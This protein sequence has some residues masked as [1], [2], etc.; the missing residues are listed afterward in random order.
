MA[1]PAAPVRAAAEAVGPT[2]A[3]PVVVAAAAG[4]SVVAAAAQAPTAPLVVAA[5]RA[6][7]RPARPTRPP[8][9][10]RR[11]RSRSVGLPARR[12]R[13]IAAPVNGATY[14]QG[15][16][17]SSSFTC[18]EG[19][20]GLGISSCVDQAAGQSG[21]ALDTSTPGS[22]TDP[23]TA[24]STDG[25]TGSAS[26]TYTVAGPPGA[27]ITA[28]ASGGSYTLNQDVAVTFTCTPGTDAPALSSCAG[29]DGASAGSGVL[30]T[31][32]LGAHTYTVTATSSDGQSATAQLAYTVTAP[33]Q[34]FAVSHIQ[35][36]AHGLVTLQV[37]APGAGTVGVLETTPHTAATAASAHLIIVGHK[38][39][40]VS[41]AT[42]LHV[43]L[44]LNPR[45]RAM[46]ARRGNALAVRLWVTYTP[47]SGTM[48]GRHVYRVPR[49]K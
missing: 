39:L 1:A 26:A 47:R 29:S 49:S 30:D 40:T 37:T 45:G 4:S 20:G 19:T 10:H 5:V 35:R 17:I 38:R 32:S 36:H 22:H 44:V 23:V 9:S 6:L 15:Q 16:S 13:S 12:A 3:A 46:L 18:T 31:T 43:S 41:A 14:A 24:T 48:S 42:K 34:P 7:A 11:R 28:P 25:L 2:W 21:A 33:S 8:A 27:S